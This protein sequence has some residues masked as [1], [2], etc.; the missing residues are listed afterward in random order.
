MHATRVIPLLD[1][2]AQHRL[3]RAEVMEA[4]TRVVD[5]Q[6]FILGEEVARLEQEIASYS[7]ASYAVGCASGTDA[8]YLALMALGI[9]PGDEVVTTPYSFFATASTIVRLGARPQFADIDE[10]TSNI[11][12][13]LAVDALRKH[14]RVKAIVQVHLFGPCADMDPLLEAAAERGIPVI[15]D[16]AQAIGA[17]YKGRRAGS[18]GRVACF[19]FFPTKNLGAYGDAG[20]LTTND[21]ALAEKLAIL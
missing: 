10:A 1:L 20:I 16:A 14:P 4:I 5:S 6:Q 17:E 19:S 13:T 2:K 15:E 9:G 8:L 12:P 3:I 21:A 18:L 11:D 7:S